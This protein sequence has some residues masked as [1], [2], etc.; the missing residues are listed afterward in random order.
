MNNVTVD[1]DELE[2]IE[3]LAKKIITGEAPFNNNRE[4]YLLTVVETQIETAYAIKDL[5]EDI[6][7]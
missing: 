2:K 5:L 7:Y 4:K 1:R 3:E 6:N